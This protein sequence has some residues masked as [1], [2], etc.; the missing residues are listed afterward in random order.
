MY[1][2]VSELTAHWL[3]AMAVADCWLRRKTSDAH[4]LGGD[5][6]RLS[7]FSLRGAEFDVDHRVYAA[8]APDDVRMRRRHAGASGLL[9]GTP[10]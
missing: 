1:S 7:R 4:L 10:G 5:Q 9:K 2:S 3:F 6:A 8:I